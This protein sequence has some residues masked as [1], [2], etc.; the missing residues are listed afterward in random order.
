MKMNGCQSKDWA[1][2]DKRFFSD[3]SHNSISPDK[4]FLDMNTNW[5][6]ELVNMANMSHSITELR[7][8]SCQTDQPRVLSEVMPT[9]LT[10]RLDF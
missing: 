9:F 3:S 2:T 7:A 1:V 4:L 6:S 5:H 8:N 10:Q